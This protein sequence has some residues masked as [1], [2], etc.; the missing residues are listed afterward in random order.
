MGLS[1]SP[2]I[3][4]L[5]S[6]PAVPK[7]DMILLRIGYKKN[8]TILD[9][10]QQD[11]LEK[12]IR[13]G[14]S[15]CKTRGAFGRLKITEHKPEYVKLEDT[16]ILESKSL[17]ELLNKSEYVLLMAATVG[18]EVTERISQEIDNGNA[19]LGVIIDSV[20]SQ[21]A[22]A[23]VAWI[24]DF[25]GRMIEREGKKLTKHRYSPGYGDLPLSN[26]KIIFDILELDKLDVELTDRFML[27]PEKSVIAIAGIEKSRK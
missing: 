8:T 19:A 4:Y 21:T 17:S 13:L 3:T 25:A 12:G 1:R 23:G 18:K 27:V 5:N 7:R 2:K 16:Y 15:L 22:D 11:F 14:S 24:M 20:A 6:I 9:K 26:Q 10:D